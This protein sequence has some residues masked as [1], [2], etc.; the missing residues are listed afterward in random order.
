[1]FERWT[2]PEATFSLLCSLTR[3]Q[4]CDI[5]G[6]GGYD[7]LEE[8][9]GVQWPV[10]QGQ[11][12]PPAAERRLFE[13]GRFF[14]DD[15]RAR[16]K[17]AHPRPLPEPTNR[18]YP[19]TLLTGRGSSSQW[20]TETRTNKSALLRRLSP[21]L[22][23]VE[24]HPQ[25]ADAAEIDADAEVVVE[26]RRGAMRAR[27]YVT[28]VVRPGHVFVPMHFVEA[29]NLTFAAFDPESRQP[30]YKACAVRVR[31]ERTLPG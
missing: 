22:P 25:D 1:M 15:G 23:Y 21:R 8:H 12:I 10:P 31:A 3:G 26:S 6:I 27:A 11:V 16:F 28:P 30:A 24:I 13:D 19:L 2:D 9:R 14:F 18:D 20:H 29:N 5:T 17:L 7:M 4:P